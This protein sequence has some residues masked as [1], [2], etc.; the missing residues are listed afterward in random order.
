MKWKVHVGSF[1]WK[2]EYFMNVDETFKYVFHNLYSLEDNL[3]MEV[4]MALV[5]IA[6]CV[7]RN[8]DVDGTEYYVEE[9]GKYT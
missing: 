1:L 4:K 8:D 2:C 6:G 5:Y 9:F 3:V 7:V